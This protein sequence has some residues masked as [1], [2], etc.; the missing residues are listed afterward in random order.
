MAPAT[1]RGGDDLS[2]PRLVGGETRAGESWSG[3]EVR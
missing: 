2:V 3:S 1:V